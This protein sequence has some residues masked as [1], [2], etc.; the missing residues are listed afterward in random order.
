MLITSESTCSKNSVLLEPRRGK[1]GAREEYGRVSSIEIEKEARWAD[2]ETAKMVKGD[3]ARDR[4]VLEAPRAEENEESIVEM[5][6][7]MDQQ[8]NRLTKKFKASMAEFDERL[9]KA[10]QIS[11]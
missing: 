2:K 11:A 7:Q 8:F 9:A 4:R 5:V 10:T 3:A 6:L 1:G